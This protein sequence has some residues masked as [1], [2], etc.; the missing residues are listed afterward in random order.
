MIVCVILRDPLERVVGQSEA[1]V[2][3]HSLESAQGKEPDPL[4]NAHAGDFESQ[5]RTHRVFEETFERVVVERAK[6]IRDIEPVVARMEGSIQPWTSVHL[7]MDHVLPGIHERCCKCV[8]KEWYD[9]PVKSFGQQRLC[10]SRETGK[11]KHVDG[12]KRMCSL[13]CVD[14][15][16][17]EQRR[18][19]ASNLP[20]AL[21]PPGDILLLAAS[22]FVWLEPCHDPPQN[23]LHGVLSQ[24]LSHDIL[25]RDTIALR[26]LRRSMQLV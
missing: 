7:A 15:G 24:D 8:L 12:L 10:C 6:S 3:I 5:Q 17:G 1:R 20:D 23:G 14:P 26:N 16:D 4:P 11:L 21:N 22:K 25:Y 13:R 9:D 2:V 18:D 19:C